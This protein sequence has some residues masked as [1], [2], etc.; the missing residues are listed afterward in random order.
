[1]PVPDFAILEGEYCQCFAPQYVAMIGEFKLV[2][3]AD[4]HTGV[5]V[6]DVSPR[7]QVSGK[8][9]MTYYRF[10]GMRY[11]DVTARARSSCVE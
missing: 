5:W 1:M 2:A 11:R 7:H 10:T 3:E 4:P 6:S 8:N 9:D